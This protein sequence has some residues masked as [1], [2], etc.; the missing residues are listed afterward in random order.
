MYCEDVGKFGVAQ[1]DVR[2]W[3]TIT[4]EQREELER[5]AASLGQLIYALW[6]TPIQRPIGKGCQVGIESCAPED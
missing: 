3:G 4:G 5:E 1:D 2:H 6:V